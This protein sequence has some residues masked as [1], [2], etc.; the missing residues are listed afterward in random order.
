MAVLST[1]TVFALLVKR[2]GTVSIGATSLF[3]TTTV[4]VTFGRTTRHIRTVR[5]CF[6]LAFFT[7][8]FAIITVFTR[9]LFV[10]GA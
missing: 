3:G 9:T 10:A 8:V 4:V 2:G 7:D 5:I 6:T 1:E